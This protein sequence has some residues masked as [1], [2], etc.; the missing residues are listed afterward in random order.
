MT[1]DTTGPNT[2]SDTPIHDQLFT[3]TYGPRDDGM[4]GWLTAAVIAGLIVL[5]V[6]TVAAS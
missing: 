2:R 1:N 5:V 3:E 4:P 6:L